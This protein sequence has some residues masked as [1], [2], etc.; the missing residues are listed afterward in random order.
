MESYGVKNFS[1]K[2]LGVILR[3]GAE[4]EEAEEVR[5]DYCVVASGCNFGFF[6]KSFRTAARGPYM[7][8]IFP[9]LIFRG[10]FSCAEE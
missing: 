3:I 9:S 7:Q 1:H 2:Y 6:D 8:A 4:A 5:F 10:L